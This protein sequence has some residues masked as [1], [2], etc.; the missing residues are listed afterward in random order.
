MGLN[1]YGYS[2][3]MVPTLRY[4]S[5]KDA[6]DKFAALAKAL[7]IDYLNYIE[8]LEELTKESILTSNLL[9]K[10]FTLQKLEMSKN[11]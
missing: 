5:L 3:D 9:K 11:K 1:Y 10:V 2:P 4:R 8:K 7:Q 6:A